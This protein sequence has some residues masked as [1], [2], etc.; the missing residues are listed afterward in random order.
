MRRIEGG[1]DLTGWS[2]LTPLERDD[3]E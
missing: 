1:E 3:E 2:W